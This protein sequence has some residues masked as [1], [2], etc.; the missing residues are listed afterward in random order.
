MHLVLGREPKT[1][2]STIQEV[3]TDIKK[4]EQ[5]GVKFEISWTPGH[6]DIHV[7]GNEYADKLA[8]EAAEEAKERKY[9]PPVITMKDIKTAVRESGRKKW[10]DMWEK[11]EKV[12]HLFN[13][14]SKL[15]IK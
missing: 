1:H 8:K 9:L 4:L 7:K 15:I 13:I 5:S 10:Q 11:S 6:S 2:K 3:K 12:R 14:R